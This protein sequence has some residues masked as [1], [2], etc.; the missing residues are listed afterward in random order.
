[1][2]LSNQEL[3]RWHWYL[4]GCQDNRLNVCIRPWCVFPATQQAGPVERAM[5]EV[6][7]IGQQTGREVWHVTGIFWKAVG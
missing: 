7:G 5:E 1:M 3:T 2:A 4:G 6:V